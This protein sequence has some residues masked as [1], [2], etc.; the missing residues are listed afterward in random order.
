MSRHRRANLLLVLVNDKPPFNRRLCV[1]N[2]FFP[3]RL[4]SFPSLPLRFSK[5][6]GN[7]ALPSSCGAFCAFFIWPEKECRVG[8]ALYAAVVAA[9]AAAAAAEGRGS[10]RQQQG[11]GQVRERPSGGCGSLGGKGRTFDPAGPRLAPVER[12]QTRERGG[13]TRRGGRETLTDNGEREGERE[14]GLGVTEGSRSAVSRSCHWGQR[15]ER[16][17][18]STTPRHLACARPHRRAHARSSAG[19]REGG[20]GEESRSAECCAAFTCHR[21]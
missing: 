1:K 4:S 17:G 16:A 7:V 8:V 6:S 15:A 5:Q 18:A 14:S 9:A 13:E 19:G 10:M 21:T 20:R 11:S 3:P 12:N 2:F